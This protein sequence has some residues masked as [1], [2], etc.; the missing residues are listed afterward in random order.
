MK[1]IKNNIVLVLLLIFT[2]STIGCSSKTYNDNDSVEISDKESKNIEIG[3]M[4]I[5]EPIVK[6]ISEGLKEQGYN[7]KA[8]VFDGNH[9]PATA[10]KD[11][12]IDGVILNHKVWLDTFN[13]E[14]D[15]NLIMP[16]PYM[17]YFRNAMYSSKYETLED[18]PEGATIAVP[19]DPA[20]LDRS[21]RILDKL[22]FIKLGDRTGEFY[23][24]V[25][26]EEN[27][28]NIEIIE[29]E[30]TATTRSMDD[31]D[32]IISGANAVRDAGYDHTKYLYEDPTNEDFP[33]GLIVRKEDKDKNWVTSILKYQ[34][35]KDFKQKFNERYD[36][37][38][39]LFE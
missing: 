11:G 34:K 7:V 22:N 10:L 13:K 39:V 38:Y 30:I 26:I 17:Y 14:N 36:F 25:D 8:V 19:G 4:A 6:F 5:T 27:V 32:A 3:C 2:L 1:K 33:L 24:K 37:T 31:V 12:T 21:L 23:S 16:E 35:D 18:I 9:L 15:S 20:N 29:T 28:K